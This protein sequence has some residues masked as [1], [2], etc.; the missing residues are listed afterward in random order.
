[1]SVKMMMKSAIAAASLALIGVSSLMAQT[2]SNEVL[3][4]YSN[5]AEAMYEDALSRA[6]ELDVAIDN[7]VAHASEQTLRDA[8]DSWLL[9][10]IPYQ[11]T[12]VFRFGNPVV[13]AW[14]GRV[15]AWPLDEGLIDYVQPVSRGTVQAD[16]R[17]ATANIIA[18]QSLTFGGRNVDV[19]SI[20]PQLLTD[21]LHEAGSIEANVATGYHAIEFLLWGQDLHGTQAGAGERPYTDYSLR[22]CTGGNCERRAAYLKTASGLLIADL[23]EMVSAWS[24]R[25]EAREAVSLAGIFTGLGS[26]S[27]GELAGERMQLGLLVHDPE[28][29]HDCFSDNTHNSHF[30]NQIGIMAV[31]SGSY[32]RIDGR[33]V[34][35][36]SVSD[37]VSESNGT[38]DRFV[39]ATMQNTLAKMQIMVSRAEAGEAYDQM[40][41][42]GNL[43]GNQVI[44]NVV[45]FLVLQSRA[46]EFA[47]RELE[48]L[49]V[50]FEGSDS[51]DGSSDIFE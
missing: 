45:D 21:T 25:G 28:E 29:E 23:Q 12:E 40:I 2:Q 9:A 15:N 49:D 46:F 18:N 26:L 48:L 20:T 24:K 34:S 30:Y 27:Y 6:T 38:L 31:Y 7:L 16:N 39:R 3:Q 35:G 43:E 13:D 50:A 1:M 8:R 17:L 19:S 37:M 51:L 5:I 47:S 14:E 33:L 32:E 36:S 4:T 10:R 11:Q 44:Q 22:D 42:E 41:G